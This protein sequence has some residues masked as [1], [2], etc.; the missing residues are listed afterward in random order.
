[1]ALTIKNNFS[2]I[3]F[4]FIGFSS[5]LLQITVLRLLFSTF[6]GNELD[7]GITLSF[8]L[9]Y[10]GLGSLF[11][12][13]IR[14]RIAFAYSFVLISVLVFP[15]VLGIKAI[16]SLLS[17]QPGELVPLSLIVISTAITILPLCL[18]T[19][20]QFPLAV[21]YSGEPKAAGII[22]GLEAVGAFFGGLLF[23]FLISSRI[24]MIDLSLFL[25]L[26]NILAALYIAKKK[27]ISFFF[28]FPL[29]F[30]FV[31]H[32]TAP[33][34]PWFGLKVSQNVE[35]R[36]GEIAVIEIKNQSSIY[37]NGHLLFTYPDKPAAEIKTHLPVTLHPSPSEILVI[38]GSPGKI[39]ELLKYPVDRITFVE[40]DPEIVKVSFS[41]LVD[42][43]RE[44]LKDK[45]LN[46]II[47]DGRRFV[48]KS[49]KPEYDLIL[50]NLPQPSTSSINRFYTTDFF[51]EAKNALKKNGI[52]VLSLPKA[53]GYIGRDM[54]LSNGSIYNSVKSVFTHVE[55]TSEEYG[56]LFAS[57]TPINT[58]PEVLEERFAER[59]PHAEHFH[60]YIFYDAFS[61][62]NVNYVKRRLGEIEFLNTDLKPSAYI[63]NL[64]LWTEIYG[65]RTLRHLLGIKVWHIILFLSLVHIPVLFLAFRRKM[66]SI[67]FSII[68]TGFSS[69][70]LMVSLI[71][72][73]Q[74]FYG[75]VYE[76]IGLLTA[77]FMIGLWAG[78]AITRKTREPL[79]ILF[80]LEVSTV[81]LAVTSILFFKGELFF[82]LLLLFSG[83][84]TGGQFNT[85][86][87]ATG[88]META[89]KIYGLELIGSFTGALIPSI[90]FIPLFG[91]YNALLFVAGIKTFSALM[92]YSSIVLF[93]QPFIDPA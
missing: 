20:M 59:A 50:L 18:A 56:G 16:R 90:I 80:Y 79:K 84:I 22:Y 71:L 67:Y 85:A 75:Y 89:G 17:L 11:G 40:I 73:Y 15:T 58:I 37:L 83:M 68:T 21:I 5:I 53:A 44:I 62:I 6:S 26:I 77:T 76:M 9:I 42:E 46:I 55:V 72:A 45:R 61:P 92:I 49:V 48:K 29:I 66:R 13:R 14:I 23:T 31:F 41:L 81:I 43:D 52:L 2:P 60:R 64:L 54:Q 74:A 28:I 3:P 69:M 51:E 70:S 34:M 7:I 93:S 38:G 32:E 82:Y 57:M 91:I 4:I 10:V 88:K 47:E 35:S 33:S 87:L 24:N 27:I 12:K 30:Y 78:T 36:Y 63:Y 19:G 86:S 25:S 8:W 39:R 1:M 65:G